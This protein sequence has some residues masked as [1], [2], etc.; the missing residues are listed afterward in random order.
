MK[1]LCYGDSNTYGYDAATGGRFGKDSRW[2]AVLSELTGFQVENEGLNGRVVPF[3]A[4]GLLGFR[5]LL[6][7]HADCG[8]MAV[9]L[10]TNDVFR[11]YAKDADGIAERLY[12]LLSAEETGSCA[13]GRRRVIIMSPPPL[14][15][16][17]EN[18]SEAAMNEGYLRIAAGFSESY[19][20]LAARLGFEFFDTMALNPEIAFDGV[21]LTPAGHRAVASALAEHIK[22]GGHSK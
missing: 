14:K 9:M 7:R 15:I 6:E 20:K 13:S 22:Q 16:R 10:G 1:V 18:E 19:K 8:A 12:I 4:R 11:L 21:H 2:P 5:E 17:P 3:G